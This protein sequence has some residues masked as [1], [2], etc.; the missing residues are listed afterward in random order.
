[1]VL[2]CLI[3]FL[4]L[5][6]HAPDEAPPP[7]KPPIYLVLEPVIVNLDGR[8]VVQLTVAFEAADLQAAAQ[9]Q[10]NLPH[11][12]NAI[13]LLTGQRTAAS[14]LSIDG[15]TTLADEINTEALTIFPMVKK[16]KGSGK[17]KGTDSPILRT[18][19]THILVHPN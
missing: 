8:S 9:L 3:A 11:I 14:L 10:A 12:R 16:V 4:S 1:M 2:L 5:R 17:K 13:L 18:F 19:F 6:S 15:K 7:L